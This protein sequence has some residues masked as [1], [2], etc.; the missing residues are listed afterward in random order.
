MEGRGKMHG[1]CKRFAERGV[2]GEGVGG[3]C[4]TRGNK[5]VKARAESMQGEEKRRKERGKERESRYL[6]R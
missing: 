5:G 3:V 1:E 6:S 4:H 2:N